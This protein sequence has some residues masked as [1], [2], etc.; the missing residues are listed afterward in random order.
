VRVDHD[1]AHVSDGIVGSYPAPPAQ[2]LCQG[3]LDEFLSLV[4]ISRQHMPESQQC[5]QRLGDE[6]REVRAAKILF[7]HGRPLLYQL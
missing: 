3:F 1:P 2:R 7:R 4:R 6:L 5:W